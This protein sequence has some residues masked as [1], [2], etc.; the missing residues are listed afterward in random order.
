MRFVMLN[1][2]ET[3][4]DIKF[5]SGVRVS[6]KLRDEQSRTHLASKLN[7]NLKL[8]PDQAK[9]LKIADIAGIFGVSLRSTPAA[10][11]GPVSWDQAREMDQNGVAIEC[12]TVTHPILTNIDDERLKLELET[13]KSVISE[14]LGREVRHFCYPNGSF[15]QNVRNAVIQ[16]GYTSAVTTNYGFCDAGTDRFRLRRIDG[17]PSIAGFAQSV[18]GFERF[19]GKVGI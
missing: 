18:S 11:Y 12:H 6:G 5:E 13:S 10:E 19:R 8:L 14:Q 7:D 1:T 4:V 17:Q 16:A 15:D 2:N 3:E 9:E